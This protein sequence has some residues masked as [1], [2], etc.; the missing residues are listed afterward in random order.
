MENLLKKVKE[1]KMSILDR[2]NVYLQLSQDH[3]FSRTFLKREILGLEDEDIKNNDE[4]I[5]RDS[6]LMWITNTV[7]SD[8]IKKTDSHITSYD[9]YKMLPF[10]E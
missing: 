2:I 1:E 7:I 3:T 4:E 8:G 9:R 5:I 6:H 10:E